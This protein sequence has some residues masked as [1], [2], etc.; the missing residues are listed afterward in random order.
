MQLGKSILG[1]GNSE[2]K[3]L[4]QECAWSVQGATRRPAHLERG[5]SRACEAVD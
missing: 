2:G 3:G 4:R 1:R 5:T